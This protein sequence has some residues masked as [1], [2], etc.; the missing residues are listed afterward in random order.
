MA[1][2]RV[3]IEIS[4]KAKSNIHGLEF[5]LNCTWRQLPAPGESKIYE[6]TVTLYNNVKLTKS[7]IITALKNG[8][9]GIDEVFWIECADLDYSK[10]SWI[11]SQGSFKFNVVAIT[12]M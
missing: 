5:A 7:L 9:W 1:E 2:K 4:N 10:I 12:D 6:C 8:E 3:T 11:K